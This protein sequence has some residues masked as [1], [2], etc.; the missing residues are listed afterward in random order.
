[1]A[2]H[3]R[4]LSSGKSSKLAEKGTGKKI[5]HGL[6][7]SIAPEKLKSRDI[8]D[9]MELV[10]TVARVEHSRLPNH[11]ID[12]SEIVS[13][14]A[15]TIH[16]LFEKHPERDFN[17]TYLST[18]MKWAVRNELRYRYKWYS[19]RNTDAEV[20]EDNVDFEDELSPDLSS[21]REAVY[22]SILSVDGLMEA[23]NPHEL[24]DE[25]QTPDESTETNELAKL[26]RKCMANLPERD[27]LLLESRYFK[28]KRMREIAD[29][30]GISASRAS[31]VVQSALNRMKAE[32]ESATYL[33]DYKPVI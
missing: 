8:K 18:A 19:L 29:E 31:R 3:S 13:I 5:R 6:S 16:L 24:R 23:E 27:R 12:V 4:F 30:F 14:G 1:M 2:Q 32:M 7:A 17:V 10:E 25:G 22:A 26:I 15:L 11:L 28:H 21:T 9:Y 33:E 20:Q